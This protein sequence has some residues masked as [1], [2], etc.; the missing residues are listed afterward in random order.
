MRRRQRCSSK[1]RTSPPS[2]P[3][4]GTSSCRSSGPPKRALQAIA[5]V[6]AVALIV[7]LAQ[8]VLKG[9]KQKTAIAYFPVAVHVYAGSDVDVLG[10]KIGSVKSVK[11]DGT[12]VK[13]EIA[14]DASR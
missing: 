6:L 3:T 5:A 14:Y 7:V 11:P 1:L 12:R 4:D 9:P 2:W 10:V 8:T 13:V